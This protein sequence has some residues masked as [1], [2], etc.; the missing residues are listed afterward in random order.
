MNQRLLIDVAPSMSSHLACLLTRYVAGGVAG[1]CCG[2]GFGPG[3]CRRIAGGRILSLTRLQ[4]TN[5][6]KLQYF[7]V[8]FVIIP[9]PICQSDGSPF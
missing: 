9:Y 2:L 7:V 5:R 3:I 6:G 8:T 1:P 4:R